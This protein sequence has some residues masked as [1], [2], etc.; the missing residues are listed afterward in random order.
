MEWLRI[1]VAS[2]SWTTPIKIDPF[3]LSIEEKGDFLTAWS[4]LARR[5]RI[6]N[7]CTFLASF[8]REEHAVATTDGAYFTQT[9]YES[10]GN[11]TFHRQTI[12]GDQQLASA[13]A[14]GL[15]RTA[16][17]WEL[18]TE[19]DLPTQIPGLY[20]A[21]DPHR[22]ALP[23]KPGTLG[24]YDVVFDAAT[25]AS[26]LNQTIGVATQLDR[27]LGYEANAGGTSYLGPDPLA[28]LGTYQAASPLVT[29]TANRSMPRGLATVKWDDEGVEPPDFPLIQDGILVD[30]QT[31]REQ[32]PWLAPWYKKQGKAIQSRGCAAADSALSITMQHAPNFV[33]EPGAE[34]I[35]FD[36]LVADINNG[37]AI[38]GADVTTDFQARTGHSNMV[39]GGGGQ[40]REIVNGRLGVVVTG[41]D[42]IFNTTQLL[43]NIQ[44]IGG[45]SSAEQM[46]AFDRKGQPVQQMSHSVRTVPA[47]ITN[48]DFIDPRR[49]A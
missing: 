8:D 36:D 21:A 47:K 20:D 15:A 27:S 4:T 35:G 28:L 14:R 17:G 48:V 30:Y 25:M 12:Y 16:A 24:R 37:L 10:E 32:A 40:I 29:V 41:L 31:T 7:F 1:P 22:A 38:L 13:S 44:V 6:E 23:S 43:K 45:A 19:A 18:F 9:L 39:N 2:G 46:P 26:L 42:F 34:A 3:T 5:Y 49:K 11:F 33:L